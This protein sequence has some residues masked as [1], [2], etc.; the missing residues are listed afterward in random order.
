MCYKFKYKTPRLV[1][2]SVQEISLFHLPKYFRNL[3]QVIQTYSQIRINTPVHPKSL[4][5][6]CLAQMKQAALEQSQD[7]FDSSRKNVKPKTLLHQD[8][9]ENCLGFCDLL[10]GMKLTLSIATRDL[11]QPPLTFTADHVS[12]AYLGRPT[13]Y[14]MPEIS[15]NQ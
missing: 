4:K 13:D 8:H 2:S 6:S 15:F 3:P 10:I 14:I 11:K 9:E 12:E 1:P 7:D 5:T